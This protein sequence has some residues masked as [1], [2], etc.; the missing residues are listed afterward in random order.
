LKLNYE[1]ESLRNKGDVLE[2]AIQQLEK[3]V[4]DEDG[5]KCSTMLSLFNG[6]IKSTNK[7]TKNIS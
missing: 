2:T 3:A 6:A 5:I 7:K 4:A 1:F